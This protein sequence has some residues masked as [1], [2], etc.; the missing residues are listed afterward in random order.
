MMLHRAY[1]VERTDYWSTAYRED[2]QITGIIDMAS[3][4]S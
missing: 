3:Y 2:L 4:L 1:G